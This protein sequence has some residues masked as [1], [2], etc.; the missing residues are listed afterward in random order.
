[1]LEGEEVNPFSVQENYLPLFTAC[2]QAVRFRQVAGILNVSKRMEK[3]IL[4]I[5]KIAFIG[6]LFLR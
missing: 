3:V 4:T 5:N 2:L 1:M 6:C